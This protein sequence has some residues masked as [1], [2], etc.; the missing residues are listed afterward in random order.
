MM[1]IIDLYYDLTR[2]VIFVAAS[3]IVSFSFQ[4]CKSV[5]TNRNTSVKTEQIGPADSLSP[6]QQ[7][8]F[9]YYYLEALRL[10]GKKDYDGAFEMLQHCLFMNP[11]SS[12][13]QFEIGQ[14]YLTLGQI[15]KGISA[16]TKAVSCEPNNYWYNQALANLY[17]QQGDSINAIKTFEKMSERFSSRQDPLLSLVDLYNQQKNYPKVISTLNRLESIMGK[18]EQISMEKFRVYFLMNDS[19]RAFNEIE[20]L[21][22]EYPSDLR[23]KVILGDVYLQKNRKKEAYDIYNKVLAAEPDN[24]M[25]LYSLANYYQATGQK[26]MYE[27]QLDTLLLNR[28]IPSDTKVDLMRQLVTQYESEG[29]DSTEVINLFNQIIKENPDDTQMPMLYVNYL[30]AKGMDSSSLPILDHIVKLDPTNT[31]ARLMLLSAAIKKED[32]KQVIQICEPGI[33]ATPDVLE[34]YF[35]LALAYNQ[36]ERYD[37]VLVT[38]KKALGHVNGDSKKEVISDFY[39]LMG[40]VL[41]AKSQ[42]KEAYAV[43]DS[44]LVYNSEN[45]GTLN[46][47]AYYLSLNRQHLDK[48][49]EMSYKTVKAE[50]NNSTYL[51]TYA[52]IL[53]IK[54]KYTQARIYIDNAMKNGGSDSDVITEHCGDIYA[55][56]GDIGN[57]L[58][59]WEKSQKLG[60][61]SNILKQK[62]V[63]KKY[64]SE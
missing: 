41:H 9:D 34:L 17:Q 58:M 62:I 38:C 3:F 56:N 7:R 22:Q 6:S 52:W 21:S 45:V 36:S 64:I 50:P 11:N 19:K 16:L 43:Y 15:P 33:E 27:K 47:Y 26:V 12:I 42:Y 40:D 28:K 60:N 31:A 25:A 54:G 59:Y 44:S 2:L 37:D 30:V 14:Y 29:R 32:Y 61:K 53:F 35:Y 48:A 18:N 8:K 20:S 5:G 1:K 46:N 13:A 55:L 63:K 10:K 23:Y 57:A 51:D 4:S 39:A 24:A 49:E